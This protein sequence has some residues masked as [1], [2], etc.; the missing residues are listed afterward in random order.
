VKKRFAQ[1]LGKDTGGMFI[2][3]DSGSN[4]FK[5]SHASV[6]VTVLFNA[7]LKVVNDIQGN[8]EDDVDVQISKMKLL[9]IVFHGWKSEPKCIEDPFDQG[10]R[11]EENDMY[12]S[13][14]DD[15]SEFEVTYDLG[16]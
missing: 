12:Q 8:E 3:A 5:Q 16:Q 7:W 10:D 2:P 15:C 9:R 1:Q 4:V 14:K 13:C 6:D 11:E